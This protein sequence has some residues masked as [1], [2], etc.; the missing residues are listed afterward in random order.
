MVLPRTSMAAR[1]VNAQVLVM[2]TRLLVAKLVVCRGLNPASQFRDQLQTP[3]NSHRF[4]P[5]T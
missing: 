4:D 2:S 1:S 5:G 3:F